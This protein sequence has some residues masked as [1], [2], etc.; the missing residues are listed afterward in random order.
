MFKYFLPRA[1]STLSGSFRT[2]TSASFWDWRTS[3]SAFVWCSRA[4]TSTF[5]WASTSTSVWAFTVATTSIFRSY[6]ASAFASCWT[7]SASVW[8]FALSPFIRKIFRFQ[9]NLTDL[10]LYSAHIFEFYYLTKNCWNNMHLKEKYLN[11]LFKIEAKNA[12][13][14]FIWLDNLDKIKY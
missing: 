12:C 9:K 8:S 3:T 4:F 5:I 14:S 2:S 7:R 6:R 11:N 13:D 1:T 10:K